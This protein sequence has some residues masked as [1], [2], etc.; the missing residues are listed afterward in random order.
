MRIGTCPHCFGD[1]ELSQL[2]CDGTYERAH[3]DPAA[4]PCP[5]PGFPHVLALCGGRDVEEDQ[6]EVDEAGVEH[7]TTVTRHVDCPHPDAIHVLIEANLEQF[8]PHLDAFL[9]SVG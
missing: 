3:G 2:P 6:V 5:I 7:T 4:Q 1:V 8:A 9:A